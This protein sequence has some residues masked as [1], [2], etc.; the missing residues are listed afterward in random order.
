MDQAERFKIVF[1]KLEEAK[2]EDVTVET[3]PAD[4]LDE[5][6]ALRRFSADLNQPEP[7]L[8]PLSTSL[9]RQEHEKNDHEN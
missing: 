1:E 8:F 7:V 6:E 4:E 5:I 3:I 9:A 2:T